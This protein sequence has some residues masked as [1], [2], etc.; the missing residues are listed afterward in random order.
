MGL[1]CLGVVYLGFFGWLGFFFFLLHEAQ[2]FILLNS[3]ETTSMKTLHLIVLSCD[4]K[5]SQRDP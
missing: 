3:V 4:L 5:T 2:S 1:G